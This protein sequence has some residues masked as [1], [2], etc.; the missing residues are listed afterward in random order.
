VVLTVTAFIAS[1][2]TI[3]VVLWYVGFFT[4]SISA[5]TAGLGEQPDVKLAAIE[6]PTNDPYQRQYDFTSGPDADWF[7]YNIPVWEK[8][9]AHLKGKPDVHYLEVGVYEGRSA[10]WI[11]ENI[12]TGA[13]ATLTGIDI[14]PDDA[15]K[16]RFLANV[17]R[18]GDE[19]KV[20]VIVGPSQEELRKLPLKHFDVVYIDGSHT[21]AD[22]LEDSVHSWR[23][24]KPGGILIF[25]DYRWQTWDANAPEEEKPKI[26]I[27]VFMRLV[28]HP[29]F[30]IVHNDYQLILRR[31]SA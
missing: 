25:D 28:G 5:L 8:A 24:L 21:S 23:L 15:V 7:T 16:N 10:M 11:L 31:K 18:S 22:V 14:F 27:D 13:G 30:D 2:L 26:G 3:L 12:L 19:D 1:A 6:R 9:L 29:H 4:S 20:T 17:K